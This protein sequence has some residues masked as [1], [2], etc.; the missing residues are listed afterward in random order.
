MATIIISIIFWCMPD[1]DKLGIAAI[2]LSIIGTTTD[3]M[4]SCGWASIIDV[5]ILIINIYIYNSITKKDK[6]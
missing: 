3:M 5:A 1:K 6:Q 2:I 4:L